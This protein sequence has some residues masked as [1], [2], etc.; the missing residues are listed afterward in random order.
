MGLVKLARAKYSPEQLLSPEP[1]NFGRGLGRGPLFDWGSSQSVSLSKNT[2]SAA[3][4]EQSGECRWEERTPN[5]AM[6][7]QEQAIQGI[8][9]WSQ[10]GGKWVDSKL[11]S[12]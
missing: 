8:S 3:K 10:S 11:A 1:T 7:G 12:R 9:N 4:E 6:G 5:P 2:T